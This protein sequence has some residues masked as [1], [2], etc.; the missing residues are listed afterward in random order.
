MS[1]ALLAVLIVLTALAAILYGLV[2]LVEF[3]AVPRDARLG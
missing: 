3:L 1:P 2:V